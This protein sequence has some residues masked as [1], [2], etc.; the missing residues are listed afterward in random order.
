MSQYNYA[1]DNTLDFLHNE[2]DGMR[3]NFE[4][5][6]K[7]V[8]DFSRKSHKSKCIKI[9]MNYLETQGVISDVE[10]DVPGHS[11]KPVCSV[12][13]L[14]EREKIGERLYFDVHIPSLC[15][16][17]SSNQCLTPYR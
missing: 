7:M 2:L 4:Y 8:I 10:F 1:D 3:L 15:Q 17:V 13:L 11:L 14:R 9:P 6:S 12:K 16:G 5:D